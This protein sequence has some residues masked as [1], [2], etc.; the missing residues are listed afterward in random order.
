MLIMFNIPSHLAA[1]NATYNML[2]TAY[3]TLLKVFCSD[4]AARF[5]SEACNVKNQNAC[6]WDD[7]N[8]LQNVVSK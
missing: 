4:A 6:L 3:L 2:I 8:Q 1:Q 7:L 5:G